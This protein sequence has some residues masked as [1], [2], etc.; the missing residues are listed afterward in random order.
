VDAAALP[1]EEGFGELCAALGED[2]LELALGGGEDYVLLFALPEGEEPPE[3]FG[4]AKVGRLVEGEELT[5]IRNGQR[6]P[7]PEI[8]WDHLDE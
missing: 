1:V 4:C 3:R 7:L 2:P 6:E 5:L 8:G